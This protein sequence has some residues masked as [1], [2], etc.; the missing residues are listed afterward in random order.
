MKRG[1]IVKL[2]RI[3]KDNT[4]VIERN[5]DDFIKQMENIRDSYVKDNEFSSK[6]VNV[7]PFVSEIRIYEERNMELDVPFILLIKRDNKR[8]ALRIPRR[9]KIVWGVLG[10]YTS[11]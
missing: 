4:F 3:A 8:E 5:M 11:K 7:L 9:H 2:V 6:L 10:G 1:R